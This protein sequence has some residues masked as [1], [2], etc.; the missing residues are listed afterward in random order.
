VS[1]GGGVTGSAH[2]VLGAHNDWKQHW[3]AHAEPALHAVAHTPWMHATPP[4]HVRAEQSPP[5]RT[6]STGSGEGQTLVGA[7]TDCPEVSSKQHALRQS[8]LA[9][10]SAAQMF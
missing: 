6:Q 2:N 1:G 8:V 5:S 10:Q 9:L 7:Q 3:L 4:Q